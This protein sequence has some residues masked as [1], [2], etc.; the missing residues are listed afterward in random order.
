MKVPPTEK[1]NCAYVQKNWCNN[2]GNR[3]F[4]GEAECQEQN[5]RKGLAT[6]R[7][8]NIC[9]IQD[10]TIQLQMICCKRVHF[11]TC[12]HSEHVDRRSTNLI[13]AHYNVSASHPSMFAIQFGKV[14]AHR[15]SGNTNMLEERHVGLSYHQ[16]TWMNQE[17]GEPYNGLALYPSNF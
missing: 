16:C 13:G 9:N 14:P 17:I 8:G 5:K 3:S 15:E 10:S 12:K 11:G 7:D 2:V 6:A 4:W 1:I